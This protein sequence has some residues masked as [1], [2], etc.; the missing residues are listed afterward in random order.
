MYSVKGSVP[1]LTPETLR[2]QG[3]GG[4]HVSMEHLLYVPEVEKGRPFEL[5]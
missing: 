4:V 3:F 2:L 5:Y 1:H